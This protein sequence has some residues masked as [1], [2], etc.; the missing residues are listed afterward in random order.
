M[1]GFCLLACIPACLPLL[2]TK[3]VGYAQAMSQICVSYK[4]TKDRWHVMMRCLNGNV[5]VWYEVD[6]G[7]ITVSKNI[8]LHP[9]LAFDCILCDQKTCYAMTV[10]H[11]SGP[12]MCC[13]H[14]QCSYYLS[15]TP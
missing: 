15:V 8:C 4:A 11:N 9:Q 3:H 5:C 13:M 7:F 2:A 12:L 10:A 6:A 14:E 1:P